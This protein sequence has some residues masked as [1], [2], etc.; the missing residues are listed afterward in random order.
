MTIYRFNDFTFDSEALSIEGPE[1]KGELRNQVRQL[2][3]MLLDTYPEVVSQETIM[4][5]VWPDTHV[6]ETAVPQLVLELRQALE[7]AGCERGAVATVPRKGYR[8]TLPF[9]KGSPRTRKKKRSWPWLLVPA[10]ILLFIWFWPEQPAEETPEPGIFNIA[11]MPFHNETGNPDLAWFELGFPDVIGQIL[12]QDQ[13]LNAIP[14]TDVLRQVEELKLDLE[15]PESHQ[16]LLRALGVDLLIQTTIGQQDENFGLDFSFIQAGRP[17]DNWHVV[18]SRPWDVAPALAEGIRQRISLN[19]VLTPDAETMKLDGFTTQAYANG[20]HLL[21][22]KEFAQARPYFEVVT[23]RQPEHIRA[24]IYLAQCALKMGDY[25]QCRQICEALTG[26]TATVP[27]ALKRSA[28]HLLAE[29]HFTMRD[30]EKSKAIA[31]PLSAD[32]RAGEDPDWAV[33]VC[34]LMGSI[35]ISL[36]QKQEAESWYQKALVTS[37]QHQML[38]AEATSLWYYASINS[39]D[40]DNL[41]YLREALDIASALGND[42]LRAKLLNAIALLIQGQDKFQEARNLLEEALEVRRDLQDKRG[43]GLGLLYLGNSES[44]FDTAKARTYFSQCIEIF[45][46][47]EDAWN[48]I[49]TYIYLSHLE[50]IEGHFDASIQQL[51]HAIDIAREANDQDAFYYITFNKVA[52]ELRRKDLRKARHYIAQIRAEEALPPHKESGAMA[53]EALCDYLEGHFDEALKKMTEAKT[54]GGKAW[55]QGFERYYDILVQAQVDQRKRPLPIEK[56]SAKWLFE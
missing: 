36:S 56:D 28:Q 9:E 53:L 41:P 38:A 26:S 49:N 37:R 17:A 29:L 6:K 8:W 40:Q 10:A 24:R 46:E 51:D 1:G 16:T 2:F 21:N 35:C 54:I 33:K 30:Y 27:E 34:W 11:M 15:N 47:L 50:N 4:A 25:D 19:L 12:D 55:H 42:L 14:I 45:K 13:A 3:E 48:L 44:R 20:V 5:Q 52:A 31:E 32:L 18:V 43:I 23:S 7:Q 22:H 39:F